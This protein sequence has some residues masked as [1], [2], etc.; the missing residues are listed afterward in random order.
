M[1]V[2][3]P[4]V[5]PLTFRSE[6]AFFSSR[7][8]VYILARLF[9]FDLVA[10][11]TRPG[12]A[13]V[14]VEQD[15]T[16][17]RHGQ[18][19]VASFGV[20]LCDARESILTARLN[21]KMLQVLGQDY[22]RQDNQSQQP[23]SID[24]T[25]YELISCNNSQSYVCVILNDHNDKVLIPDK[26]NLNDMLVDNHHAKCNKL[27]KKII[28]KESDIIDS[29]FDSDRVDQVYLPQ[30][31]S[32][33]NSAEKGLIPTLSS[34]PLSGK[35]L[36]V[37][38]QDYVMQDKQSQQ[39][40]ST[41]KNNLNDRLVDDHLAKCNKLRMKIIMKESDI[42]DSLFDSDRVDRVYLPRGVSGLNPTEKG[43]IP[44]LSSPPLSW[45]MLQVLGQDYVMQENQSQQP[46]ST[47]RLVTE[48]PITVAGNFQVEALPSTNQEEEHNFSSTV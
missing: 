20:G 40:G 28:M 3:I 23:S 32:G 47:G 1:N 30:G 4:L 38:G 8:Q 42:I 26:N 11:R 27:R 44:A 29:L 34:L 43:L 18:E 19:N 12:I 48:V 39:P 5:S 2:G 14:C 15:L 9:R 22:V 31:V 46:A 36:Q 10:E 21:W 6:P 24:S 25:S 41:D 13:R 45:K 7:E 35:M 37:L 17:P 33:L 16:K